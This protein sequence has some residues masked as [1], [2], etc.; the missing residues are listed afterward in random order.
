MGNKKSNHKK[1]NDNIAYCICPLMG[2]TNF[3]DKQMN[4]QDDVL[5]AQAL[6]QCKI[7]DPIYFCRIKRPVSIDKIANKILNSGAK[8]R[9]DNENTF[10]L[11]PSL[12]GSK[13]EFKKH[14]NMTSIEKFQ[15]N[16][17]REDK[18][19]YIFAKYF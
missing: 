15:L 5:F 3:L 14:L 19:F 8:G 9:Y 18:T 1:R 10:A 6:A 11:C 4:K 16:F 13:E 12:K 2:D 7:K 17:G